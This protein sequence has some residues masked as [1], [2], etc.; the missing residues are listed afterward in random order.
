MYEITITTPGHKL[1]VQCSTLEDACKAYGEA[2]KSAL[3][4]TTTVEVSLNNL[5]TGREITRAR[6]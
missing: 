5:T 1:R 3:R 2:A 6:L 4:A